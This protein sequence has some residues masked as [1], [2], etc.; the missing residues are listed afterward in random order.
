MRFINKLL[1][2]FAYTGFFPFAPATFASFVFMAL[3]W[4]VPGGE[5]LVQPFVVLATL[6]ISVPVATALE[7][8]YG[9]DAS[10]IVIDEIVGVQV[11]LMFAAPTLAGLIVAFFLWRISD[12]V[13][14]FPASR[15]QK[16]PG[17]RGVVFDDVF[18]ALYARLAMFVLAYFIPALGNFG[19]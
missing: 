6:L 13:K 17:G 10:C 1:G 15:A 4:L 5:W 16:W 7:K 18:A 2:T 19:W 9:H 11:V 12:I 14:P 3:Y 8:Q